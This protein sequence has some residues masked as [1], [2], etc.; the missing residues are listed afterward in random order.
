MAAIASSGSRMPSARGLPK[1]ATCLK[2]F[3]MP[4]I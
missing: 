4:E 1:I 2:G 3:A